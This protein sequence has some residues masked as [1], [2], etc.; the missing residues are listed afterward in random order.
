VSR[1]DRGEYSGKLNNL[2]LTAA[3]NQGQVMIE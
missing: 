3:E 2:K 1:T